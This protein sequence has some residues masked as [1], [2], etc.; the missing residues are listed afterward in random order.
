MGWRRGQQCN[1]K[2]AGNGV[3]M[4]NKMVG[5]GEDEDGTCGNGWGRR[6]DL[7]G[8]MAIGMISISVQVSIAKCEGAVICHEECRRGAHLPVLG[9]EPVGR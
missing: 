6:Q 2:S 1:A 4:G 9:C 5:R 8:G 3:R 7:W